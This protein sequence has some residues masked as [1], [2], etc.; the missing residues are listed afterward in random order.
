MCVMSSELM[1]DWCRENSRILGDV[2]NR[3]VWWFFW[4][5]DFWGEAW[6]EN[7]WRNTLKSPILV[8]LGCFGNSA[9]KA[10]YKGK[11]SIALPKLIDS[12]FLKFTPT[13]L[14]LEQSFPL[15]FF[16]FQCKR[17]ERCFPYVEKPRIS[18]TVI[19]S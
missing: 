19:G 5:R 14:G 3:V 8:L 6:A 10:D 13:E 17:E 16:S 4:N 12:I 2:Q 1:V 18:E 11:G 9:S 15:R 7:G